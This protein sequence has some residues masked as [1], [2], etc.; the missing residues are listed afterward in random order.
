MVSVSPWS[1]KGVE[2]EAREAAKIAARRSAMTVGQWLS[3]T[4]RAAAA[5]QLADT[6]QP[7]VETAP[8]PPPPQPAPEQADQGDNSLASQESYPV[9]ALRAVEAGHNAPPPVSMDEAIR[10][11][12][13]RLNNPI[14]DSESKS[15]AAIASPVDQVE[16]LSERIEQVREQSPLLTAPVERAVSRLSERLEKIEAARRTE[17]AN[18]RWSLFS[19]ND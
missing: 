15:R 11:N 3:Q 2:P 13:P 4:I 8:S 10:E 17:A 14:E 12:I 9:E 7:L 6:A 19:N 1:V 5:Q 16:Q 18:R